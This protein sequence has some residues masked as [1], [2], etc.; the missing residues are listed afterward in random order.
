MEEAKPTITVT[1]EDNRII[2]EKGEDG[3]RHSY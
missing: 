1:D 2:L 3:K